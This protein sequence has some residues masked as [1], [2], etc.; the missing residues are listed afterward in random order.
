M[1]FNDSLNQFVFPIRSSML[2]RDK[3][4]VFVFSIR[5]AF[6]KGWHLCKEGAGLSLETSISLGLFC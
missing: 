2:T 5:D 4:S 6:T 1:S 3:K